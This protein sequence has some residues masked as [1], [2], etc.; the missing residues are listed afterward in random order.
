MDFFP[1]HVPALLYTQNFCVRCIRFCLWPV[2]SCTKMRI[3]VLS[4]GSF[5]H[6]LH[7]RVCVCFVNFKDF[8]MEIHF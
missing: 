2:C 6:V 4:E 3:C 1:L 7:A 5:F 8:E